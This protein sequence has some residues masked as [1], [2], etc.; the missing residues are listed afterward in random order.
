MGKISSL[1]IIIAS[2]STTL[3]KEEKQEKLQ[4][5][6]T[7]EKPGPMLLKVAVT[8]VKLVVKSKLSKLMSNSDAA[9]TKQYAMKNTLM[10]RK[11]SCSKGRPFN[12]TLTVL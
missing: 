1:P 9:N 3:D 8:A 11:V 7:K 10:P 4:V 5:G 12:L 6:P 2:V